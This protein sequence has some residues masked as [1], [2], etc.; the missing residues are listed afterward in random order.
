MA[1]QFLIFFSKHAPGRSTKFTNFD[2]ML[3]NELFWTFTG[4]FGLRRRLFSFR[5]MRIVFECYG[6]YR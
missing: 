2:A 1:Y 5:S 6:T 4:I 3:Q